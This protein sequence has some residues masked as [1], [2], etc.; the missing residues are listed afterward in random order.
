MAASVSEPG[1]G[2]KVNVYTTEPAI[3]LYTG[4]FLDGSL[5]KNNSPYGFREGFC[6]ET[7][8]YPDSPNHSDFPSALLNPG[9]TFTSRTIFEFEWDKK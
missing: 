7:Q 1:S 8:N 3:H 5:G 9:E 4:N 6:L 2:R